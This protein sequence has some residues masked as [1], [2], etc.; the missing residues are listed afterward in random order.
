MESLL[1]E[2]L[3]GQFRE[4]VSGQKIDQIMSQ[5]FKRSLSPWDAVRYLTNN[6]RA[7]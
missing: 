2:A 3:M 6:G 7:K 4:K 1:Q 5:V